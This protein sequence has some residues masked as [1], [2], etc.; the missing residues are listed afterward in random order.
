MPWS[1]SLVWPELHWLDSYLSLL[2][3][4]VQGEGVS[5]FCRIGDGGKGPASNPSVLNTR[6]ISFSEDWFMDQHPG[7]ADRTKDE[8][9]NPQREGSESSVYCITETVLQMKPDAVATSFRKLVD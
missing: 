2:D 3:I 5:P 7:A 4:D 1:E 6:S 9:P 8:T